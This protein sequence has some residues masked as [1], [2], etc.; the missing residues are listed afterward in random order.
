MPANVLLTFWK[1]S[2]TKNGR[3]RNNWITN[4]ISVK[5]I[6]NGSSFFMSKGG[7][8]HGLF[9]SN[10]RAGHR[11]G[12]IFHHRGLKEGVQQQREVSKIHPFDFFGNRGNRGSCMLLFH[13]VHHP[14]DERGGG[15]HHR[16]RIRPYRDWHEPDRQATHQR[17]ERI[18]V[19]VFSKK[20]SKTAPLFAS[21]VGTLLKS[22]VSALRIP[23]VRQT[24]K[25]MK[26]DRLNDLINL[27]FRV[28]YIRA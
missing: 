15:N 7:I 18:I 25:K 9:K 28:M 16:C 13:P 19:S 12:G 26:K 11:V 17:Q 2:H 8:Y 6:F 1:A 23:C 20:V 22:A 24:R 5:A 4:I 3:T 27:P 21:T 14:G 10:Q